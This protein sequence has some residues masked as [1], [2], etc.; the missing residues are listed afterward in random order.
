M[1]MT[2]EHFPDLCDYFAEDG[3]S[4][5]MI[6]SEGNLVFFFDPARELTTFVVQSTV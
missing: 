2:V 4:L 3:T 1:L 5:H 6:Q